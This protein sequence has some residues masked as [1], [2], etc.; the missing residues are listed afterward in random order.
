MCRRGKGKMSSIVGFLENR[1]IYWCFLFLCALILFGG[2]FGFS[3][4]NPENIAYV[5]NGYDS[6]QHYFGWQAY[7]DG[8]FYFLP[9][10]TDRLTYPEKMSI[11]FTDPIPLLAFAFKLLAP[12]LPEY[13]SFV[14]HENIIFHATLF[15]K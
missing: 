12:V 7:R 15:F 2:I 4:L 10:L 14:A 5:Y 11:I 6:E 3:T 9:G 1:K 13:F 8:S